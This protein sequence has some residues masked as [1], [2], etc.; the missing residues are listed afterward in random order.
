MARLMLS[1]GIFSAFAAA[2]AVRSRGLE[3]ASPPPFLAAMLISFISR[4]KI[5]PRL[6][7]SA[8]FLCLIVAHFEWPDMERPLTFVK[9]GLLVTLRAG[10]RSSDQLGAGGHSARKTD[11][12]LYDLRARPRAA[13]VSK[14]RPFTLVR[15]R[16]HSL[17]GLVR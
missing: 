8:P 9:V 15:T 13:C 14:K 11:L 10:V 12:S 2:V 6:A 5:L 4:V 7:S 3:S 1:A 17:R 16:S